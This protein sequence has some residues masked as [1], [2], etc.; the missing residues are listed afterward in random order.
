MLTNI[1]LFKFED[2]LDQNDWRVWELLTKKIGNK[3]QI[4]GDDLTVTNVSRLEKAIEKKAMNAILIKLNQIGTVTETI[5]AINLA[6]DN[7]Y[8]V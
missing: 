5:E 7:N 4:V 8:G 2:G 1:Q 3:C 6:K